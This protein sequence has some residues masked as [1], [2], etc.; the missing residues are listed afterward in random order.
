MG[1]K[2]VY[3]FF[4]NVNLSSL[5]NDHY[6]VSK[7]NSDPLLKKNYYVSLE[8]IG[9]SKIICDIIY[10]Y[11]FNNS[12]Y[13]IVINKSKDYEI[14]TKKFYWVEDKTAIDGNI[15][16]KYNSFYFLNN[17]NFH[18]LE[19]NFGNN[20]N[21]IIGDNCK[22]TFSSS[23]KI[24]IFD[25]DVNLTENI[26]YK[27]YHNC[28]EFLKR[29]YANDK[30]IISKLEDI[31]NSNIFKKVIVINPYFSNELNMFHFN[32]ITDLYLL[33]VV[34]KHLSYI[35]NNNFNIIIQ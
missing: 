14:F 20:I 33:P 24:D 17:Y 32:N 35:I 13:S 26:K 1:N 21:I 22:L 10:D 3:S 29:K 23:D 4:E 19:I 18:S 5:H 28:N 30:K 6:I 2:I 12:S 7:Y 27:Y 9:M 8:K 11:M 34:L 25:H 16:Y 15:L 31:E